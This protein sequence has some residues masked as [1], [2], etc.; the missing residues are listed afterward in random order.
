[1]SKVISMPLL[2]KED[3]T[4]SNACLRAFGSSSCFRD[5][6]DAET[7]SILQRDKEDDEKLA[8]GTQAAIAKGVAAG[9][10]IY[11]CGVKWSFLIDF[12]YI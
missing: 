9:R 7:A 5:V 3:D 12:F 11:S 10:C 1:M 6:A 2:A 8:L 4:T